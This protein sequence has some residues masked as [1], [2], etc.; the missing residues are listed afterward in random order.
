MIFKPLYFKDKLTLINPY[1][2]VGIVTLWSPVKTTLKKLTEAKIDLS[3]QRSRIAV[4]GTLYGNGLPELLRNL[5]YNPQI[6]HIIILGKDLAESRLELTQFFSHGLEETHFLGNPT[7][8][9]IGTNRKMD[10]LVTPDSFKKGVTLL[11]LGQKPKPLGDVFNTL[12]PKRACTLERQEIPIPKPTLAWHPSDPRGHTIIRPTPLQA[13]K[14]LIFQLVRFGHRNQ[15]KKGERIELQNVKVVVDTPQQDLESHLIENGLSLKQLINYQKDIL[16]PSRP[17]EQPYTYGNRIR[18]YFNHQGKPLDALLVAIESLKQDRESRHIYCAL[19]DTGRDLIPGSKGHPCLVSL[20]FR[21]FE[22][23]LTLTATFRTHNALDGWLKNLY[24]LMAIQTYVAEKIPL[25]IGAITVF[26][27]SISIDPQGGGL[28]RA[29]TIAESKK[30]DDPIDPLTGKT[31]LRLDPRGEFVVT[32]DESTREMVV[33]HTYKGQTIKEYRGK[34]SSDIEHQLTRDAA[35]SEI[36]H[37]LYMG[38]E[39]AMKEMQLKKIVKK[40][41]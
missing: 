33:L 24:G 31:S 16:D 41:P 32:L 37:A 36:S 4:I 26:S 23:K 38:R 35:L 21:T 22:E 34:R 9:I 18:G 7:Q 19:W 3:P 29:N 27:H 28:E 15:L 12:P 25:P 17:E 8:Q 13:W 40:E 20:F 14:E 30:T 11:D 1:G 6:N 5:L 39:L 10:G 2:D